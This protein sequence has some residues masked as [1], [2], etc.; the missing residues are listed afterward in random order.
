MPIVAKWAFLKIVFK[1]LSLTY[2][3]DKKKKRIQLACNDILIGF[4]KSEDNL[5]CFI[6]GQIYSEGLLFNELKGSFLKNKE[7]NLNLSLNFNEGDSLLTLLPSDISSDGQQ[8]DISGKC[9]LNQ[10]LPLIYLD[11]NTSNTNYDKAISLLNDHLQKVLNKFHVDQ[12]LSAQVKLVLDT[13]PGVQPFANINFQ[14]D[15]SRVRLIDYFLEDVKIKGSFNNHQDTTQLASD[16]NSV[17]SISSSDFNYKEINFKA[18][19]S[20]QNLNVPITKLKADVSGPLKAFHHYLDTA[21][22]KFSNG[23]FTLKLEQ[24]GPISLITIPD[25]IMM[26]GQI[27]VKLHISNGELDIVKKKLVFSEIYGDLNFLNKNVKIPALTCKMNDNR[28][29]LEGDLQNMV[30]YLL[31]PENKIKAQLKLTSPYF[32]LNKL[33][34]KNDLQKSEESK[35]VT[36]PFMGHLYKILSQMEIDFDINLKKFEYKKLITNEILG[37]VGITN[38]SVTLN[39]WQLLLP[40]KGRIRLN[41]AYIFQSNDSGEVKIDA[42]LKDIDASKLFFGFNNFGQS[43]LTNENLAGLINSKVNFTCTTNKAFEPVQNT[44]RGK[45]T[46]LLT[47]GELRNFEP[48]KKV[49]ELVFKNRDLMHI[50]FDEINNVFLLEGEELFIEKMVVSSSVLSLYLEGVFSFKHKTDLSIQIPLSNLK[51]NKNEYFKI[52]DIEHGNLRLRAREKDGKMN[53]GLDLFDRYH[54]GKKGDQEE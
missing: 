44:I 52:K 40:T 39:N 16:E 34:V 22:Y 2:L 31:F 25:P 1:N 28:L 3:D 32:N 27:D 29:K 11:I 4:K 46:M 37:N 54:N 20:L 24:N 38:E 35:K 13:K 43:S 42:H 18:V 12:G 49:G 5:L 8:Y 19:G 50:H 23:A 9:R 45:M 21:Y 47:E 14:I 48:L 17:L 53:I 26:K 6:N 10:K 33:L 30:S 15:N 7:L 41:G 36:K 51:D